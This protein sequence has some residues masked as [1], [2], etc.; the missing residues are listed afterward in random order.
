MDE[1]LPVGT[2]LFHLKKKKVGT[3]IRHYKGIWYDVDNDAQFFWHSNEVKEI[4]EKEAFLYR[5]KYG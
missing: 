3:V 2:I 5:I 4:T 1:M